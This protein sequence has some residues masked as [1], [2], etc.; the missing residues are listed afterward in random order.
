M[1]MPAEHKSQLLI[2]VLGFA[3]VVVTTVSSNWD[4]WFPRSVP[5][6]V[7]TS[8]PGVTTTPPAIITPTET[9]TPPDTTT[10]PASPTPRA[11][12]TP[13]VT[14]FPTT[15]LKPPRHRYPLS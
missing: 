7:V 10:P 3:G 11:I 13:R 9:S 12:P 2:A 1:G 6:P 15:D 4:K 14:P 8:T 5:P